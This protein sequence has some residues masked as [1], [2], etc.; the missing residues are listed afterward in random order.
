MNARMRMILAI[1][2]VI[3]VCALFFF[4]FIRGRQADLAK[5]ES[6]I[7]AEENRALQLNTELNRL[8]DLQKRAP[9]LEAELT[10]IRELVPVE[11]EVPNYMFLVQDAA[12]EA[13]VDF[14]SIVPELPKAPPEAAPLAQVRMEISADGGFFA[15]QDFLRRM[16]ALDR[17]TRIDNL[18]ISRDETSGE[19]TLVLAT[20][21]FFELPSAPAANTGADPNVAP[22]TAP[23]GSPAAGA[24]ATEA[25]P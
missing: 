16:Y 20:R 8:K 9:E 21:I 2:G 24:P 7:E 6:N 11:H 5:V 10:R 1:V 17:A 3:V 23:V 25:T 13:G 18:V 4:F 22:P 15:L 12:T 19:I 14:V